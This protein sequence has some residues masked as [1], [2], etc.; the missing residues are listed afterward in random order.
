MGHSWERS[1]NGGRDVRGLMCFIIGL[2]LLM[3]TAMPS[4]AEASAQGGVAAVTS[5]SSIMT[6]NGASVPPF[7]QAA[8]WTEFEG[9]SS[10]RY[11]IR[12]SI[13]VVPHESPAIELYAQAAEKDRAEGTVQATS[14]ES[15]HIRCHSSPWYFVIEKDVKNGAGT[16]LLIKHKSR[17]EESLPCIYVVRSG[18][19]EIKNEW[20]EYFAGLR[21]NLLILDS[22]TGP[23]PSGLIIWDLQK[24]KK[25]FEDSWADPI[26]Q[27]DSI[28]YWT[29]TGEATHDNCP[30]LAEWESN[31]LGGAIETRVLLTFSHFTISKT[32]ETRCSPRQ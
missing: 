23:G 14:D 6:G 15:P 11:D 29:E 18:D 16:D 24:R 27:D 4:G 20:A 22:T 5:D 28:L 21:G 12:Q 9:K 30:E 26:I 8:K 25:V 13:Y 10:D 17:A 3:P 7:P 1:R 32:N 2:S 31:G 19:L